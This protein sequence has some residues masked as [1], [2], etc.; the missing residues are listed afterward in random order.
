V[1][2]ATGGLGGPAVGFLGGA[3]LGALS[4]GGSQAADNL[5]HGRQWHQGVLASAAVGGVLGGVS[6]GAG[7]VAGRYL[8]RYVSRAVQ[9]ARSLA[10][11]VAAHTASTAARV[12]RFTKVVGTGARHVARGLFGRSG[13]LFGNPRYGFKGI[14]N[15][16]TLRIGWGRHQGRD[17][18]RVAVGWPTWRQTNRFRRWFGHHH[19]DIWR[20]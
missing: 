5:L 18:F 10:H 11:K 15:R 6:G 12:M 17:V 1:T 20:R 13:I 9:P 4:S 19:I 2:G 8:G 3:A 16:G 7:S 14:L